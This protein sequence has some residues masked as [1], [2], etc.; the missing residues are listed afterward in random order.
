[1][2]KRL[3]QFLALS[4]IA[5]L[6]VFYNTT[7]ALTCGA[8]TDDGAGHCIVFLTSNPGKGNQSWSV[9][10][11]WNNA[12]NQVACIGSGANGTS[13]V[14]RAGELL[15]GGGSG[16]G[17]GA[18]ASTTNITLTP[19]GT[20]TYA[21]GA[22]AT[23]TIQTNDWAASRV[24]YFNS[25][26]SST[27]SVTCDWGQMPLASTTAGTGGVAAKSIGTKIF[28][29]G[30]GGVSAANGHGGSA[31]GGSAGMKGIGKNGGAGT[32]GGNAGGGGGGGSDGVSAANGSAGSGGTGGAG[33]NGSAGSGSGAGGALADPG[34]T[35]TAGTA[36]SGAGGG[37]GGATL[38][39]GTGGQGGAGACDQVFDATH[40]ACAGGGG[41]GSTAGAGGN[42]GKGGNA[43]TYGGG[44]GAAGGNASA[45]SATSATGGTGGQS[46]IVIIYTPVAAATVYPVLAINGPIII[47]GSLKI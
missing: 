31:G 16:S 1:M 27:A 29:G 22:S 5:S 17:G 39:S 42:A 8:G 3:K 18:Y 37:G 25:T 30:N 33:G 43:G 40:G 38:S 35:G 4:V 20:A 2:K 44:G 47:N 41:G 23:N 24:T 9:P 34:G 15:A 21:I 14:L 10:S 6:F 36:N 26:A 32:G 7:S 19:G 28:A 45:S 12:N 11:D 13:T 46:L